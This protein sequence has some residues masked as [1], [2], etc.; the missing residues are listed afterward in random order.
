VGLSG[1]K[2]TFGRVAGMVLTFVAL[3]V[4]GGMLVVHAFV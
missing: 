4:A 3:F 2:S 1:N